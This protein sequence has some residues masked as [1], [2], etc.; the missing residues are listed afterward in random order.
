MNLFNINMFIFKIKYSRFRK[1]LLFIDRSVPQFDK[2][3]GSRSAYHWLKLFINLGFNVIFLGDDFLDK[4]PYTS[5][6]NSFGIEILSGNYFLN[7]WK[8]W[9][10]D[11]GQNLDYVILNRPVIAEKYIDLIK[12]CTNAKIFYFGQDLHYLRIEREASLAN[13]EDY[14]LESKRLKEIEYKIMKKSDY[15]Y[16]FSTKE[17]EIIKSFDPIINCKTIPLYMFSKSKILKFDNNRKNLLFVGN[18]DHSPNSDGFRWLNNFILPYIIKN[19][20]EIIIYVIGSNIPDDIKK[21]E[22]NSVKIL[23]HIDDKTLFEFY[24]NCRICVVPLRFG[25]GLKGK[26]LEA[27]YNQIPIITTSIGAEGLPAENSFLVVED[28]HEKFTGKIL[29]MY[30]NNNYLKNITKN[31]YRYVMKH[32]SFNKAIEIIKSDF[33]NYD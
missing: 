28:D 1:N 13:N 26:I 14:L 19:H 24:K 4:E 11:N 8:Q 33:F 7:N 10:N 5:I 15:V 20:P 29:D 3:A 22:N 27:M 16:Y 9:L 25:A 17:V 30:Y 18:F 6:L 32:F 12:N 23:G 21:F 2:D 31:N